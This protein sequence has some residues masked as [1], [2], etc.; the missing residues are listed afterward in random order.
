MAFDDIAVDLGGVAGGELLA[1]AGLALDAVERRMRLA[2]CAVTAKPF[3]SRCFTHLPQ[4]LQVG[5]FQ[6]SIGHRRGKAGEA[7]SIAQKRNQQAVST[8]GFSFAA[9][10]GGSRAA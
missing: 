7:N 9:K 8:S 6:T 1:D 10:H 5:D 3:A 2:L 4:H